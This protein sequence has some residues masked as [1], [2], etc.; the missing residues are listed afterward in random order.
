MCVWIVRLCVYGF[1]TCVYVDV[2]RECAGV[3]F[4]FVRSGNNIILYTRPVQSQG[5][6]GNWKSRWTCMS[7]QEE[8][9]T[10][11]IE[12]EHTLYNVN[13]AHLRLCTSLILL[14]FLFSSCFPHHSSSCGASLLLSAFFHSVDLWMTQG[15]TGNSVQLADELS[16]QVQGDQSTKYVQKDQPVVMS[17]IH[18]TLTHN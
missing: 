3:C 6:V 4:V 2:Y 12:T 18:H 14:L 1:C 5:I 13:G 9:V 16:G 15:E 11:E 10:T 7:F 8:T 17:N